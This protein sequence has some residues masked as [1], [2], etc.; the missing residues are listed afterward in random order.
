M[1][2][3]FQAS[4]VPSG[5]GFPTEIKNSPPDGVRLANVSGLAA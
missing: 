5:H 4:R 3:R 1:T 2:E